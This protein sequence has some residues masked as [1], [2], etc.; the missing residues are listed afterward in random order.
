[1]ERQAR[2]EWFANELRGELKNKGWGI[3]TLARA[4]RPGDIDIA[5]RNIYRWVNG[6]HF[7]QAK[8]RRQVAEALGLDSDRFEREE[9]DEDE[10]LA[11]LLFALDRFVHDRIRK[12]R[13][14]R[15][16]AA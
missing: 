12:V 3:Q 16:V 10:S 13:N 14:E 2:A 7:P 11:D 5:R 6:E 4:M 15:E 8:Q 1:M 9:D